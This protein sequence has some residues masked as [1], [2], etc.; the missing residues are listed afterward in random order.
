M[1]WL[2]LVPVLATLALALASD[3][4]PDRGCVPRALAECVRG[5][6]S[7]ARRPP[8]P[9]AESEEA[10]EAEIA[11]E[12]LVAWEAILLGADGEAA[13]GISFKVVRSDVKNRIVHVTNDEGRISF[14][15]PEGKQTLLLVDLSDDRSWP[16]DAARTV[17]KLEDLV[18]LDLGVVAT[19]TGQA[20]EATDEGAP[21]HVWHGEFETSFQSAPDGAYVGDYVEVDATISI[22]ARRV[23][24]SL[25]A[26][27]EARLRLRVL[28]EDGRAASGARIDRAFMGGFKPVFVALRDDELEPEEPSEE[29]AEDNGFNFD[30]SGSTDSGGWLTVRG[31]PFLQ[32][33][34]IRLVVQKESRHRYAEVLL[35]G[36]NVTRNLLVRLPAHPNEAQETSVGFGY[37]CGC[38]LVRRRDNGSG[39]LTVSVRRRNGEPAARTNVLLHLKGNRY[40]DTDA[41][42][43]V[44]FRGLPAGYFSIQVREVGF[45]YAEAKGT[46]G[47]GGRDHV[48]L[49]EPEGWTAH[50]RVVSVEGYPLPYAALEVRTEHGIPYVRLENDVQTLA[51]YTDSRG[52]ATLARLPKG[53]ITVI[54]EFGTR[55]ADAQI[56]ESAPET[57][58]R[59]PR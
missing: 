7:P 40:G 48:A 31:V 10:R 5:R 49:T 14:P 43:N 53:A 13:S 47:D 33:E 38:G 4:D 45:V 46:L 24:M 54:A 21:S 58:L 15:P 42:G 57:T 12:D 35:G 30:A 39:T 20:L 41:E 36:E 27:S 50:L 56:S 29:F 37:G 59:L 23:R 32:G 3:A 19:H 9:T 44:T 25:P 6:G 1:R 17:L 22:F 2:L 52:E 51:L 28:E 18:P 11:A 34:L 26:R 55:T 16:L 8:D